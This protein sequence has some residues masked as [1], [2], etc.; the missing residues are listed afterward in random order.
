[1]SLAPLFSQGPLT[2]LQDAKPKQIKSG[3]SIHLPFQPLEA[4][5]LPFH[6]TLIPRQRTCSC[7]R[8][9]I[10]LHTFRQASQFGNSTFFR[11]LQPLCE[12]TGFSLGEDLQKILAQLIC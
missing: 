8:G 2:G 11:S 1:M 12:F 4:I 7:N 9:T 3:T 5:D 10:L 6:L